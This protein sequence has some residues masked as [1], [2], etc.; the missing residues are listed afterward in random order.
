MSDEKRLN[1]KFKEHW[2][3]ETATFSAC[4]LEA[5]VMDKDGDASSWSV[6]F[7][8]VVFAS[9]NDIY[10]TQPYH[11]DLAMQRAEAALRAKAKSIRDEILARRA[12]EANIPAISQG[13]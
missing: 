13:N 10:S 8:G 3:G 5:N 11:F 9:E 1:W 6:R 12:A 7:R 4:G 2:W